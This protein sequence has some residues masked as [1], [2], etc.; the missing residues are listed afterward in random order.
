MKLYVVFASNITCE[1]KDISIDQAASFV[2]GGPD[3]PVVGAIQS[4]QIPFSN[5]DWQSGDPL[6]IGLELWLGGDDHF[7]APH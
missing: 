6:V 1:L 2:D 4:R 5:D 3:R 7:P